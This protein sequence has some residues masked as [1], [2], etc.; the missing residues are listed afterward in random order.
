MV[1][2]HETP[3]PCC[4][5]QSRFCLPL[6]NNLRN[7]NATA[8]PAQN[9]HC[10]YFYPLVEYARFASTY[11]STP[12]AG[13]SIARAH[14]IQARPEIR[15][16]RAR[17]SMVSRRMRASNERQAGKLETSRARIS[18]TDARTSKRSSSE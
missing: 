13:R 11:P 5:V 18:S 2:G 1:G 15:N 6:G 9:N 3:P 8:A 14:A 12:N 7:G 17:P 16:C 4:G 10:I